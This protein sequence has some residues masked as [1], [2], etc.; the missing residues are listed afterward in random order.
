MS[1]QQEKLT[2]IADAIREKDGSAEAISANDFADRIKA[3]K[4]VNPYKIHEQPLD[5]MDVYKETR[6]SDWLKMP[7][8]NN[9]EIYMLVHV[10]SGC[11]DLL[12]FTVACTSSTYVVEY[13][14]VS[15]SGVFTRSS[16]VSVTAGS[17]HETVITP[18]QLSSVTGDGFGQV[19]VYVH[20]TG[21]TSFAMSNHSKKVYP[22]DFRD[23]PVV[24]IAAKC[25][26]L[27]TLGISDTDDN[28]EG[29][30]LRG[31]VYFAL[32][33]TNNITDLTYAF[34]NCRSLVAILAFDFSKV[35]SLG[36]TF[37]RCRTL[38][39]LPP[40]NFPVCTYM[41][42]AFRT[43]MSLKSVI[44]NAPVNKTLSYT[45]YECSSL[46]RA[47][48]I[49]NNA[50]LTNLSYAFW[51]NMQLRKV[52]LPDTSAVTNM[53]YMFRD[54]Q[55]LEHIPTINTSNVT[56]IGNA[57]TRCFNLIE[58]PTLNLNKVTTT[59]AS[60]MADEDGAL[61]KVLLANT[62]ATYTGGNVMFSGAAMDHAACVALINSLP[63]TTSNPG[64]GLAGNPGALELTAAE[65]QVGINKGWKIWVDP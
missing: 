55:V 12:A 35:K 50:T 38:I 14:T 37:I 20:G 49:T 24:E 17:K 44:L 52:I 61:K 16:S 41:G 53:A 46:I 63:T 57:F 3:I 15:S 56:T 27:T 28:V 6:P 11:S 45:F 18:S 29:S 54:C 33:G 19:M 42:A 26:S 65:K 58:L 8:P 34:A 39:A 9:D 21:I 13:G 43:C 22:T 51:A 36:S 47:E 30:Q 10:K 64:L 7:T 2:A 60:V 40:L 25:P 4:V 1:T 59:G 5:P 23:W 31:L 62:G 48:I 32:Y